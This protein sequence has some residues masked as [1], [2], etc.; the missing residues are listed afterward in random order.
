MYVIYI[1]IYVY[2]YIF[3]KALAQGGFRSLYD[4][5]LCH[6]LS[7]SLDT[8]GLPLVL[9][10]FVTCSASS[11][12][13]TIGITLLLPLRLLPGVFGR[14]RARHFVIGFDLTVLHPAALLPFDAL[15]AP[16]FDWLSSWST[17]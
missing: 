14:D 9:A 4:P 5:S 7:E 8:R 17:F 12:V 15:F 3:T 11:P 1:Y 2:I 6:S 13:Q 10:A 16:L